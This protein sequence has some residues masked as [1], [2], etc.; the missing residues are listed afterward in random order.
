M[1]VQRNVNRNNLFANNAMPQQQYQ[2]PPPQQPS[3]FGAQQQSIFGAPQQQSNPFLSNVPQAPNPPAFDILPPQSNNSNP[4][5]GVVPSNYS[6]S[7]SN[8]LFGNASPQFSNNYNPPPPMV[9]A[10]I[11]FG[12]RSTNQSNSN[13]LFRHTES[14]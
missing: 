8:S 7:N 5:G 1:P 13:S 10:P 14:F 12:N 6:N 2:Q 9:Q 4:F 3:L 11:S